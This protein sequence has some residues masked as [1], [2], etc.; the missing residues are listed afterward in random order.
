MTNVRASVA[1]RHVTPHSHAQ[2][3]PLH[4]ETALL[5]LAG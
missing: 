4:R 1:E 3:R 5:K 2:V